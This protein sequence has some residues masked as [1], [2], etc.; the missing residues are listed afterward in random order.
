MNMQLSVARQEVLRNTVFNEQS[1]YYM[2]LA[3]QPATRTCNTKLS[4][5]LVITS[6]YK[7]CVLSSR[8]S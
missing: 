2:L 4:S 3:M 7:G 1:E 5:L 6:W 8:T